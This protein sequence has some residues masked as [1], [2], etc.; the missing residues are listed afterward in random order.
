MYG[1]GGGQ[2]R[3]NPEEMRGKRK[4]DPRDLGGQM[5]GRAPNGCAGSS[6]G[7]PGGV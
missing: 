6:K 3:E 4:Q 1:T 2:K 7:R 5:E